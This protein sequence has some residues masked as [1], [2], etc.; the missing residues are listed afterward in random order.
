[1]FFE[2]SVVFSDALLCFCETSLCL[3]YIPFLLCAA[4]VALNSIRFQIVLIRIFGPS[5]LY[6]SPMRRICL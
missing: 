4:I 6:F 3:L 1:M 5:L 2:N